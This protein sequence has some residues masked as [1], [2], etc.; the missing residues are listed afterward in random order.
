MK[1]NFRIMMIALV[2]MICVSAIAQNNSKLQRINREQL[3]EMQAKHI[4]RQLALDDATAAKYIQ[5]YKDY[6]K[7]IWALG[8]R[9]KHQGNGEEKAEAAI[10][11]R[12]ERSQQILSIRE[13]Y[14]EKY[15]KFLTQKQ[16]Q[17]AYQLER[18]AMNNIAKRHR[19]MGQK[20]MGNRK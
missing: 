4:A 11:G 18:K 19:G 10:K 9:V 13:K 7:D 20:R 14:Y 15:S 16:L 6:Q 3:A 17:K 8:P 5:T 2:A 1:Q 12:F